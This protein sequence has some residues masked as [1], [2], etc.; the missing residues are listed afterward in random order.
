MRDRPGWF[1]RFMIGSCESLQ[2]LAVSFGAMM[3][4]DWL[5]GDRDVCV[6]ELSPPAPGHPERLIPDIPPTPTEILLWLE[7]KFSSTTD[8]L[9]VGEYGRRRE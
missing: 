2:V 1:A 8:E 6:L 5:A 7:L 9:S 4:L 3:P